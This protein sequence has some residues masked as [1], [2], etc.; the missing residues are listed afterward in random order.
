MFSQ[1]K[2]R[3]DAAEHA[4]I[5]RLEAAEAELVDLQDR[6][7]RATTWLTERRQRNHFAESIRITLRGV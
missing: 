7:H 4:K 2:A 3:R 5:V 6:A 1:R